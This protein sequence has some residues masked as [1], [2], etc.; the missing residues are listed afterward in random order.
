VR[1][2]PHFIADRHSDRIAESLATSAEKCAQGRA[3]KHEAVRRLRLPLSRRSEAQKDPKHFQPE[4]I[5]AGNFAKLSPGTATTR[6]AR[7]VPSRGRIPL[8]SS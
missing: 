1:I 7:P 5:A 2:F 8:G 4:K 3:L 6:T